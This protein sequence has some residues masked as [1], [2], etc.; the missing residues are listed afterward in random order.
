MYGKRVFD[1]PNNGN[2]TSLRDLAET[3]KRGMMHE[4]LP[5]KQRFYLGKRELRLLRKALKTKRARGNGVVDGLEKAF[6]DKNKKVELFHK[7]G[8]ASKWFSDNV[9]VRVK[10]TNERWIVVMA[11][12]SGRGA[13]DQASQL[14][15][16]ILASDEL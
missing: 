3:M 4:K 15:G 5:K 14:V 9:F 2:C 8:Y 11:N 6:A 10:E 12:Y 13:L 16:E 7:A 1:C